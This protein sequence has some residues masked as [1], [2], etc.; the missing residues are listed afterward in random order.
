M[1]V[2][3]STLS[4]FNGYRFGDHGK[5]ETCIVMGGCHSGK[6][7]EVWREKSA[8]P[9]KDGY[10]KV[11]L[12]NSE[13]R[14]R[15][16]I[17]VGRLILEAFVG[18]CPDGMEACHKDNDKSNNALSNLRWGTHKSNMDDGKVF[19]VYGKLKGS[20]IGLSKLTESYIPL[21]RKLRAEGMTQKEVAEIVGVSHYAICDIERGRTWK[22]VS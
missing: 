11:C 13:T 7:T 16:V 19:G 14:K 15:Q 8:S 20:Q 5:I 2:N 4:R 22:H 18:P 3:Y 10:L 17:H 21:V 12:R 6:L 9:D 1:S